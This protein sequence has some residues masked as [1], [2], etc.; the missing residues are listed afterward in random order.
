VPPMT[1]SRLVLTLPL[2]AGLLFGSAA[3][4]QAACA[5]PLPP[6]SAK[7]ER[8]FTAPAKVISKACKYQVTMVTSEGT[9]KMKLYPTAAPLTVNSFV[10]LARKR[11]FDGLTFHRVLADFVIQ[12]GDPLG[13][14]QGDPGYKFKDELPKTPYTVGDLVMANS[15][16]D[17]N[18]SQFFVITGP[19]G[20][21]LPA[22]YARFGHVTSGQAVAKRIEKLQTPGDSTGAPSRKIT[23]KTV[24]VTAK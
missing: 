22:L 4:A 9:M 1:K 20:A 11:F 8:T 17:T 6:L 10:F 12:G 23:I 18:G 2:T 24:R 19:N 21:A 16:P 15:G 7:P 5:K 14:G 3:S 13:N